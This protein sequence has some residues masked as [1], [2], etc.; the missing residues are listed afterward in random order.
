MTQPADQLTSALLEKIAGKNVLTVLNK[1]DLT[2]KLDEKNLPPALTQ[3]VKISAKTGQNLETLIEQIKKISRIDSLDLN[4][5][6][7][8][9]ERQKS[10]LKKLSAANSTAIASPLIQQLLNA[11]LR[12]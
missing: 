3:K 8:T 7:C 5:P 12:V 10:L 4:A 1:S 6:I 2:Q 9:T 11:P